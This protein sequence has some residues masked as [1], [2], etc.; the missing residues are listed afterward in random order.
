[1]R[2]L[3]LILAGLI[4]ATASLC[5][6]GPVTHHSAPSALVVTDVHHAHPDQAEFL[7]AGVNRERGLP[8]VAL[9]AT[10]LDV[11]VASVTAALATAVPLEPPPPR[12]ALS[13]PL[14][15]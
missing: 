5:P 6:A 14:R 15:L 8:D 9:T 4:V 2:V 11:A 13:L 10:G 3:G 7:T 12:F 1:M